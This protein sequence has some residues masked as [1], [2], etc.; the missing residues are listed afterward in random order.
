MT[1]VT[2]Y[3]NQHAVVEIYKNL[4]FVIKVLVA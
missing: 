1:K 3:R 2:K 4:T